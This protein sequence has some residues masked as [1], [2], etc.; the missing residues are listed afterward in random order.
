LERV[1]I[2]ERLL[3]S[4]SRLPHFSQKFLH[5]SNVQT[6]DLTSTPPRLPF[7]LELYGTGTF[8]VKLIASIRTASSSWRSTDASTA[9][10]SAGTW[11]RADLVFNRD[12][13]A[14]FL[15]GAIVGLHAFEPSV[16]LDMSLSRKTI[17]LGGKH[18]G[19][20]FH[21]KFA[22]FRVETTVPEDLRALL[23][24]Q[25]NTPQWCVTKKLEELRSAGGT[26][27]GWP[28][29]PIGFVSHTNSWVQTFCNGA[30]LHNPAT[31]TYEVHGVIR[32]LYDS[33]PLNTKIDLGQLLSDELP[34]VQ[35]TGKESVFQGGAIYWSPI[36][37]PHE[38][39]GPVYKAYVAS[40]GCKTW[41][42]PVNEPV[43][44]T[45]GYTQ[46][47]QNG[48]WY[49]QYGADEAH[50]VQ[51]AILRAFVAT[52]GLSRWGF[53]VTDEE[54]TEVEGMKREIRCSKFENA[55][56]YWSEATGAHEVHGDILKVWTQLG[57]P[58]MHFI[59]ELGLP[60]TD[61]VH[62]PG[63]DK[64]EMCGFE[65]GVICAYGTQDSVVVV[66]PLRIVLGTLS[67]ANSPKPGENELYCDVIVNRGESTV[68]CKRYPEDATA[69]S[70][71]TTVEID[72]E[73]P[74]LV[75]P[76]A[77][78]SMTLTVDVWDY[79]KDGEHHHLGKWTKV[80]DA[81]NAWGLRENGGELSSGEIVLTKNITVT[82][83]PLVG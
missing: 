1:S 21:G 82:V 39:T 77:M 3:C 80:L 79:N 20:R 55:E 33:L 74:V 12:T 45:S 7:T 71:G 31:G 68:F 26:D 43:P 2:N 69:F 51:G 56:W 81:T 61:V 25:R 23:D 38:I 63:V 24:E 18:L 35:P 44:V 42:F 4:C 75:K 48:T 83:K 36:T 8:T 46:H 34:T 6:K 30:I 53:P 76:D 9:N 15:D 62:I 73:L 49:Y 27:L 59:Q 17:N 54:T 70:P 58:D 67:T 11:H 66:Y 16:L 19:N 47:M 40:G 28:T 29:G 57:G 60:V 52:G 65:Q 50:V 32:Q 22:A 13:L 41:G 78:S 72:E 64:G 10:V 37:G 14:V 5:P